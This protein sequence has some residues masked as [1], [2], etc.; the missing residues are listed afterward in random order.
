MSTSS[1]RSSSN[2]SSSVSLRFVVL[3]VVSLFFSCFVMALTWIAGR[4]PAEALLA[5]LLAF[6]GIFK[7]FDNLI[8]R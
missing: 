1:S 6:G 7:F 8:A 2:P 4:H 3:I 5:S